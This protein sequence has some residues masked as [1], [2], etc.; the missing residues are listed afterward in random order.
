[1]KHLFLFAGEMSA[2]A[3]GTKMRAEGLAGA[4]SMEDFEVMGFSD[5]LSSL[6]RL[7]RQFEHIKQYLFHTQPDIAIFLDSPS[8]SLR[9]AKALRRASYKGKLVQYICPTIWAWGKH[10]IALMAQTLDLLLTIYPF[11]NQYFKDTS[12]SVKYVGHPLTEIIQNYQYCT[13]WRQQVGIDPN[14]NIIAIFPGSRLGEIKRNLPQQI[15]AAQRVSEKFP[16]SCIAISCAQERYQDTLSELLKENRIA[17]DNLSFVPHAY[18]Y[19]LMRH[20]RSAIA[21]SGTVTLELA[22]HRCPTVVVYALTTLNRLIAK[23]VLRLKMP[24]YCIV[25]ILLEQQAFPELIETGSLFIL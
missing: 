23:Y 2:D 19:E 18:S 4:L 24:H 13:N 9:M 8:F 10:R 1:M 7:K 22:L 16:N 6:P 5:V 3:Y 25:N 21:K 20:S 17:Y 15:Q 12:L 14:K 11:E